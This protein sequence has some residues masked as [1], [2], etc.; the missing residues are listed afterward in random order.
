MPDLYD[1]GVGSTAD[2]PLDQMALADAG[3]AVDDNNS[4]SLFGPF[5][6]REDAVVRQG[7]RGAVVPTNLA[8]HRQKLLQRSG[9]RIDEPCSAMSLSAGQSFEVGEYLADEQSLEAAVL[10][11]SRTGK[12]PDRSI[13]FALNRDIFAL[14]HEIRLPSIGVGHARERLERIGEQPKIRKL[15]FQDV[16]HVRTLS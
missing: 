13:G 8:S 7:L 11:L 12:G 1:E 9:I 14:P 10:P 2:D 15:T 3:T 4:Q 5:Q 16:V 6:Y